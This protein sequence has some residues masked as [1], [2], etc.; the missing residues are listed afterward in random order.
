MPFISMRDNA[1]LHVRV[2]GRGQPVLMLPGLGMASS[3]WLPFVLPYQRSFQFIMPDFRGHGRSMAVPLNQA[4]VF[5][6]HVDDV[7]DVI[8]HFQLDN[9]LLAGISLG[10]TT[11]M[12][13]QRETGFSGVRRYLHIDQSPNVVNDAQWRYGLAGEKQPALFAEMLALL[14]LL[15]NHNEVEYFDQLPRDVKSQVAHQVAGLLSILG[16]GS[17]ALGFLRHVLPRFPALIARKVP[18]MRLDD[19]RAYLRCYSG[20]GH[21]YRPSLGAGNTPV[22]LMMGMNSPL[23]AS[24][25]QRLVAE[26]A[27]QSRVVCFERSGHVPLMDEPVKFM[28]EFGRFL[29]EDVT[30][31]AKNAGLEDAV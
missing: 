4:D 8:A 6:N 31:D 20:A 1:L 26:S 7:R 9:Y 27:A 16:A 21:D 11:A 13:L 24:Q 17:G 29:R 19:M 18:L 28:R 22:T 2:I 23:Y 10:A 30:G 14:S 25:G 3:H 12:H 5:Q 15:D